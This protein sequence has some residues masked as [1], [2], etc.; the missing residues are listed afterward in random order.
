MQSI[1]WQREL[2]RERVGGGVELSSEVKRLIIYCCSIFDWN[3]R[4]QLPRAVHFVTLFQILTKIDLVKNYIDLK[5]LLFDHCKIS[6]FKFSSATECTKRCILEH[7]CVCVCVV[8]ERR[9]TISGLIMQGI[10]PSG[11]H[12]PIF[13]S[14]S[15]HSMI[16]SFTPDLVGWCGS[17]WRKK[18]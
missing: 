18:R 5:K 9:W 13:F 15:M 17:E 8:F 12:L 6:I 10:S 3:V 1:H 11:E 2:T 14:S 16:D 4:E 7:V